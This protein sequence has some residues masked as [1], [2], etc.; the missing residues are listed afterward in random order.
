MVGNAMTQQQA[1]AKN[2]QSS[3]Q[4]QQKLNQTPA[5]QMGFMQ[6]MALA[7][8]QSVAKAGW[9][10][11]DNA[12]MIAGAAGSVAGPAG[13]AG[14]GILGEAMKETAYGGTGKEFGQNLSPTKVLKEGAIQAAFEVP[15]LAM[16]GI[17]KAAQS[18]GLSEKAMRFALKGTEDLTGET[19][20]AALMNKLQMKAATRKQLFDQIG[21]KLQAHNMV[22]DHLLDA[23]LPTSEKVNVLSTINAVIDKNIDAATKTLDTDAVKA[24]NEMKMAAKNAY[25]KVGYGSTAMLDIKAATKI[26]SLFGKAA[27]WKPGPISTGYQAVHDLVQGTRRQIYGAIN[28]SIK[29]AIKA[30]G[31]AKAVGEN[32]HVIRE[33]LEAQD[34]LQAA[35][36]AEHNNVNYHTIPKLINSMRAKI[37]TGLAGNAREVE[38]AAPL[39]RA[40]GT[41]APNLARGA[42]VA[43]DVSTGGTEG[44]MGVPP[45]D[46]PGM[47]PLSK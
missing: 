15:G 8:P 34:T 24:L 42:I 23:A 1:M 46:T 26:K 47:T 35:A 6:R 7:I 4:L 39:I 19:N 17:A 33:A 28:D 44:N 16:K 22:S 25:D 14:G 2:A 3:Q 9:K 37:G 43:H 38:K 29:G 45:P 40:A 13:A 27:N 10:F 5:P 11:T 36:D 20:P 31:L 41:V 12:P 21:Q 32:N 30:P 18:L